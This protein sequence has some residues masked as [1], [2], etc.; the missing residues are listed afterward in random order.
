MKIIINELS[1]LYKLKGLNPE[2]TYFIEIY[3]HVTRD[4]FL[5]INL[6]KL[7]VY[8]PNAFDINDMFLNC[9]INDLTIIGSKLI[10][11]ND[12]LRDCVVKNITINCDIIGNLTL[13]GEYK[14]ILLNISEDEKKVQFGYMN[15]LEH[16]VR[17]SPLLP[18]EIKSICSDNF[19]ENYPELFL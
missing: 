6:N 14:N 13:R 7:T 2:E 19:E 1:D 10:R 4:L 18:D 16:L 8:V 9:V 12:V 15:K 17:R 5:G 3:L 11:I